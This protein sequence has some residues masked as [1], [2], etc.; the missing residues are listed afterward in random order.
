MRVA[1]VSPEQEIWSGEANMVVAR[2]RDGEIGVLPRHVPL[3]GVLVENGDV[4]VETSAG[5]HVYTVGGGFISVTKDGVS[6]LAETAS[7]KA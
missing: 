7:P 3:L 1:I 4:K 6:I 2:T 5:D